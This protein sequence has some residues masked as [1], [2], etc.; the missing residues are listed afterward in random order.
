LPTLEAPDVT[1]ARKA[2]VVQRVWIPKTSSAD[3][4][5]AKRLVSDALRRE[6]ERVQAANSV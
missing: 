4:I 6:G 1:D 5:N 3:R 2:R